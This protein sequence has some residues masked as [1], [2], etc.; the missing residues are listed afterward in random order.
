LDKETGIKLT[1]AQYMTP[2]NRKIQA[3]G[4]KP[5]VVIEEIGQSDFEKGQKEDRY[6]REKDLRGHLTATI[7][8]PEEKTLREETE[9]TERANRIKEIQSKGSSG[10]KDLNKENSEDIFKTYDPANDY[11]V[12]QAVRYLQGY[13]VFESSMKTSN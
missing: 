11:Q 5:D 4:I 3:I 1:I 2:K 6:I 7:E 10:S 9:R 13:K 12:L 8:T